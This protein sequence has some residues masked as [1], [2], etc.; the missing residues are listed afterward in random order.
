MAPADAPIFVDVAVRPEGDLRANLE[1]LAKNL[2]GIDDLGAFAIERLE[3]EAAD[4]GE[5]FDYAKDVEPWLGE[6]AGIALLEYDGDDFRGYVIAVATTDTGAAQ[7][8]IDRQ[9]DEVV[10]EASYEDTDFKVE[11]DGTAVGIVGDFLV[12]AESEEAFK[13]AVDAEGGDALADQDGYADAVD[14]APS[15][16]F[17]DVFVDVGGLIEESGGTVDP[18]ARQLLETL[19]I[20]PKDATALASVVPGSNRIEIDFSTNLVGDGVPTGDASELLGSLPGGSFA[21]F[22][23][24][25][26]GEYE[27][28]I[29]TSLTSN[30]GELNPT[31]QREQLRDRLRRDRRP[32]LRLRRLLRRQYGARPD[33]RRGAHDH[34]RH[35]YVTVAT[36]HRRRELDPGR[37]RISEEGI[38]GFSITDRDNLGAQPL[39]VAAKGDRVAI[40]YGPVAAA[41]AL[42]PGEGD[43]LT[44]NPAFQEAAGASPG[45]IPL[46][47][48]LWAGHHRAGQDLAT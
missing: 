15:E 35:G 8:F 27:E 48:L 10:E 43:T 21:A 2:A 5:D 46:S 44:E 31:N 47:G 37:T 19:G 4:D 16:S 11:E 29:N 17:A 9:A 20:E 28:A 23:T 12:L 30:P 24:T 38:T 36:R 41:A 18:E 42:T 1:G 25:D 6:R 39:V 26:F 3:A 13:A 22:A 14:A 34:R 7:D 45:D 32:D 33:R 40:S